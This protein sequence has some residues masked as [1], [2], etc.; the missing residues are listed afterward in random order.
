LTNNPC[1]DTEIYI[2]R[3]QLRVLYDEM[4]AKFQQLKHIQ[5]RITSLENR[6]YQLQ[7]SQ[8]QEK[9]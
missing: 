3:E 7:H 4:D 9:E 2:A 6:I 5:T 8:Q 1:N